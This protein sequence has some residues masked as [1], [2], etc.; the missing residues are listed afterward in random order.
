MILGLYMLIS[1]LQ[2]AA[3]AAETIAGGSSGEG[4]GGQQPNPLFALSLAGEVWSRCGW[5]ADAEAQARMDEVF[6]Q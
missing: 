5:T 2:G 1:V 3:A 4:G 6:N